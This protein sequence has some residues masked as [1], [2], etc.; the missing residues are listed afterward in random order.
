MSEN[1]QIKG[2]MWATRSA[3]LAPGIPPVKLWKMYEQQASLKGSPIKHPLSKSLDSDRLDEGRT[4]RQ[5]HCPFPPPNL[6]MSSTGGSYTPRSARNGR[7]PVHAPPP[8][9]ISTQ[10]IVDSPLDSASD[11]SD[12]PHQ[13]P[14]QHRARPASC[15]HQQLLRRVAMGDEC[16]SPV[17]SVKPRP[18]SAPAARARGRLP[19]ESPAA[20]LHDTALSPCDLVSKEF[21]A[22]TPRPDAADWFDQGIHAGWQKRRLMR[23]RHT[24]SGTPEVNR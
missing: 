15:R 2:C 18:F 4:V 23:K 12:V 19:A 1:R 7:E 14:R 6:A 16:D 11:D 9:N 21:A 20:V 24:G 3:G 13:E 17:S 22:C 5:T 8:R 10:Y